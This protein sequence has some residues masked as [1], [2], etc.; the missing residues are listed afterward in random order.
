LSDLFPQVFA[1]PVANDISIM[2]LEKA[3]A[4]AYGSFNALQVGFSRDALHDLTGAPT[5]YINIK[6]K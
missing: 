6:G 2:I 4:H 3:Y 1:K 5:T